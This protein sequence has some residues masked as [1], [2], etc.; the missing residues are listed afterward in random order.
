MICII[1]Q[2][3]VYHGFA[4]IVFGRV[5]LAH[6]LGFDGSF[7][8]RPLALCG[9]PNVGGA[10]VRQIPRITGICPSVKGLESLRLGGASVRAFSGFLEG[11]F[12]SRF[13]EKNRCL[14]GGSPKEFPGIDILGESGFFRVGPGSTHPGTCPVRG[15]IRALSGVAVKITAR[16]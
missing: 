9:R 10:E 3:R 15:P 11:R 13:S 2:L 12:R 1:A 4:C 6:R 8:R 14:E 16:E 7:R 5:S